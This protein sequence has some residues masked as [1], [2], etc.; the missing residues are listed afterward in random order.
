MQPKAPQPPAAQPPSSQPADRSQHPVAVQP[1]AGQPP[2][3]A[4]APKA[5]RNLSRSPADIPDPTV[6]LK[7]GEM[8]VIKLDGSVFDF[9]RVPEGKEIK[10][11]FTFTN[12]GTGPLEILKVQPTCGCTVTGA[13]DKIVQPG[14]KGR[15]PVTLRV[16]KAAGKTSKKITV[17]T[18]IEGEGREA[19]L[20]LAGEVWAPLEANPRS[21]SFSRLGPEEAAR[22]GARQTAVLTNNTDKPAKLT[23][24][25]CSNPLFTAEVKELEPGKTFELVVTLARPLQSGSAG[26]TV[27]FSTGLEEQ[28]TVQVPIYASALPAVEVVPSSVTIAKER[29]GSLMRKLVVRNNLKQPL[30]I[31]EVTPSSPQI[32]ATLEEDRPGMA[33][34]VTLE[35]P[36]EYK[37]PENGDQLR[38]K[39]DNSSYPEVVVPIRD[40][41]Y[42]RP[43]TVPPEGAKT[44]SAPPKRPT[45]AGKAA[46]A[47]AQPGS[48]P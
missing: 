28:P 36:A 7:P 39:T 9:G 10:H 40:D 2:K 26:G 17:Y 48:N 16:G 22:G 18:N 32:K 6:V 41:Q 29:T 20:M 5:P 14:G 46:S 42:L 45:P 25:R 13:Y 4:T 27:E 3:G 11:E 30:K 1:A 31:S 38:I 35:I 44:P 12:A 21:V 23:D 15:I 24:V 47:P 33:Y 8:P 34:Q 37:V 43:L 19:I